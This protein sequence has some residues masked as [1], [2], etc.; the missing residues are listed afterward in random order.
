MTADPHVSL[1]LERGSGIIGALLC[2]LANSFWLH[3]ALMDHAEWGNRLLDR[4][5]QATAVGVAFWGIAITLLIA[6]ETKPIVVQLKKIDYFRLVVQYFA[7][8]LFAC[9]GLLIVSV[10]LEPLSR[11]VSSEFVSSVWLSIGVWAFVATVRTYV[12]WT[13]IISRSA[14]D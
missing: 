10:V 5:I 12:V 14:Q 3:F 8:S 4:V 1:M 7:E 6:L 9:L 13:K 2:F 11:K